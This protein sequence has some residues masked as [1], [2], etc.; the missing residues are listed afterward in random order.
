MS[1]LSHPQ[2]NLS[3]FFLPPN[4]KHMLLMGTQKGKVT[5]ETTEQTMPCKA[6]AVL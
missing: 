5:P 1:D 6:E 3:H 4:R 2:S